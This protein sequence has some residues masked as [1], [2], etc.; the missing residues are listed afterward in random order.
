[1]RV[2]LFDQRNSLW[3]SGHEYTRAQ[4]GALLAAGDD[5]ELVVICDPPPRSMSSATARCP[6]S[7][8]LVRK[9]LE[10]RDS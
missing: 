7:R 8:H 2:A 6:A 4:A 3:T 1:M 5:T 10:P 9:R